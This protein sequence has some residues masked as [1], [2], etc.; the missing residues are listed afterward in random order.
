MR[1]QMSLS[2]EGDTTAADSTLPLIQGEIGVFDGIRIVVTDPTVMKIVESS[3]RSL[4][5]Q[6]I[7]EGTEVLTHMR[8]TTM[9]EL[10]DHLSDPRCLR[11]RIVPIKGNEPWFRKFAAKNRR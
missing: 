4:R 10:A 2:P 3:V 6:V 8:T 7:T 5:V 9:P 1:T 11:S